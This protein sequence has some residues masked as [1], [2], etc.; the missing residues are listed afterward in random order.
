MAIVA[1]IQITDAVD[2][3]AA[4]MVPDNIRSA[5]GPCTGVGG[6]QGSGAGKR[7]PDPQYDLAWVPRTWIK[8]AAAIGIHIN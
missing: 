2:W 8:R 1:N 7:I 4:G 5:A 6:G 3:H